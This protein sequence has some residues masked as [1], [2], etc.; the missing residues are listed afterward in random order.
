MYV[1]F[2]AL[3]NYLTVAETLKLNLENI[4]MINLIGKDISKFHCYFWPL[5]LQ[6]NNNLP[7]KLR[8]IMH[9][10]WLKNETKM[11]K[12]I[13]N[14]VDPFKL[15]EE[16]GL[17][18]I[19]FYFISSG[20][21]NHDVNF[22]EP[23]IRNVY[24]KYIPDSLS[25]FILKN[26]KYLA[27]LILRISNPRVCDTNK[28]N[29]V[30]KFSDDHLKFIKNNCI[31]IESAKDFLLKYDFVAASHKIHLVLLEL[32]CLV[33]STEYWKHLN[34]KDYVSSIF[35]LVFEFIRIVTILLKPYLPEYIKDLNKFLGFLE[36]KIMIKYSFFRLNNK[37]IDQIY[38]AESLNVIKNNKEIKNFLNEVEDVENGYYK[39]KLDLKEKIFI[40]KV[41]IEVQEK[42]RRK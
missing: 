21:L 35:C 17:D 22:D 23:T 34:D 4:E 15:I 27:N 14:V 40:N 9:N 25:K 26:I 20:P 18:A 19:R 1:W 39:L 6:L 36:D 41:K 8:I 5:I 28:F 2:E 37:Q 38:D 24:Y 29:I 32:N 3:L 11:S 31:L 12:S 10:H 33:H 7:K 30:E 16:I 42:K 13:G